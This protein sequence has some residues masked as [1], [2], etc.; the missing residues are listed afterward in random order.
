VREINDNLL[1][2]DTAFSKL[3]ID[4]REKKDCAPTS[5]QTIEDTMIR[6]PRIYR[7]RRGF[8]KSLSESEFLI[9]CA[10]YAEQLCGILYLWPVSATHMGD[11]V[12]IF[13]VL[14]DAANAAKEEAAKEDD[15]AQNMSSTPRGRK[16]R[17]KNDSKLDGEDPTTDTELVLNPFEK[18]AQPFTPSPKRL[19]QEMPSSSP[20]SQQT[21]STVVTDRRQECNSRTSK[22]L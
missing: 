5:R 18:T 2:G 15:E 8:M 16:R 22:C 12:S 20:S 1:G 11:F 3:Q 13:W 21:V 4:E 9:A 10:I 14:E 7:P 19:R 6:L 17:F